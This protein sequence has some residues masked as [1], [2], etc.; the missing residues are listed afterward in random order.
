MGTSRQG[1]KLTRFFPIPP[2]LFIASHHHMLY[3]ILVLH[4]IAILISEN[5]FL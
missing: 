2:S 1:S 3:I 4:L 5:I